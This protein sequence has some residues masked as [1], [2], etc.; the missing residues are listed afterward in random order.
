MENKVVKNMEYWKKKNNIPGIEALA[1]SGLTDGRAGSSPFQIATLGSSPNKNMMKKALGFM[2]PL[3]G[4]PIGA[5]IRALAPNSQIA[6][7][8][9]DPF[10]FQ[11][12]GGAGAMFGGMAGQ[13]EV[14]QENTMA[15]VPVQTPM[16]MQSPMKQEDGKVETIAGQDIIKGE[17]EDEGNFYYE[18]IDGEQIF[19]EDPDGVVAKNVTDG[20]VSDLD[21]SFEKT[22]DGYY[23][24]TGVAGEGGEQPVRPEDVVPSMNPGGVGQ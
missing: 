6:Q 15:A 10:G 19:I 8:M 2:N 23:K 13:P 3:S 1:D 12:G 24:V 7:S 5:G 14:A 9:T 18:T 17:G 22:E 4:G 11:G 16:V 21:F 20:M